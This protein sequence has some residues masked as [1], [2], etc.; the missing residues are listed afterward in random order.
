[1]EQLITIAYWQLALTVFV[2]LYVVS[3]AYRTGKRLEKLEEKDR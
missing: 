1:M 3:V 2:G